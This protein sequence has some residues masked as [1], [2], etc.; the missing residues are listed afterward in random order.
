MITTT[1]QN[2]CILLISGLLTLCACTRG[3]LYYEDSGTVFH[4]LYHIKYQHNKLLTD[5]IDKEFQDFNLSLNPFLPNSIITKV[6]RNEDVEVDE[7]FETVFNKAKEVYEA[8]GGAF[9]PTVAPLVNLW[10]FGFEH[11]DSVSQHTIDSLKEFV[12]FNKIRIENKHVI[13]DDPRVELNFSAI[14]KGFA[15]DVIARL[16]EREDVDNYMIEIGGEVAVSGKNSHGQCWQIGINKP[17]DDTTGMVNDI[18]A[19]VPLCDKCGM[20][21]SGN[22][23]NF[24][25]KNGKKYGHTIDPETGYPSERNILSATIIAPDCMTAD[26][27]ATV[28]MLLS[29]E[30]VSQ[31]ADSIG[32]LEYYLIYAGDERDELRIVASEGLETLLP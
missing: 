15:S 13:K 21:T 26:A 9:D 20:A 7:W 10:G 11:R 3:K 23:R 24:Y 2:W 30:Q 32:N 14:A 25:V 16:M 6:N 27:Y 18:E 8:S 1:N 22:Y 28:F 4:T 31:M 29:I 19:V 5:K 17:E 12:G